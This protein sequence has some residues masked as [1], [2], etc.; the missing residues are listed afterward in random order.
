MNGT[1]SRGS[2][3]PKITEGRDSENRQSSWRQAILRGV[4][5]RL[6]SCSSPQI[7]DYSRTCR[8]DV[9]RWCLSGNGAA[10]RCSCADRPSARRP[11]RWGERSEHSAQQLGRRKLGEKCARRYMR[12][13]SELRVW[14]CCCSWFCT[15]LCIAPRPECESARAICRRL[16]AVRTILRADISRSHGSSRHGGVRRPF[17]LAAG[18][19]QFAAGANMRASSRG[20]ARA[21]TAGLVSWPAKEPA[22]AASQRNGEQ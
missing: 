13:S 17:A 7:S 1:I 5:I 15:E 2:V 3:R 10:G 9:S 11:S 4:N 20:I 19:R 6:K 14:C 8:G 18:R 16:G 22:R 21:C 12:F